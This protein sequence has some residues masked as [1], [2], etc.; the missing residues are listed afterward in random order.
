MPLFDMDPETA[1]NLVNFGGAMMANAGQPG[2]SFAGAAGAGVAGMQAGRM[3]QAELQSK[4][5]QNQMAGLGL[6]RSQAMQ[7][8]FLKQAQQMGQNNPNSS[9]GNSQGSAAD[10]LFQQAYTTALMGGDMKGAADVLKS[11]AEHN[12]ALAGQISTQQANAGIIKDANGNIVRAGNAVG[13]GG[14]GGNNN[15]APSAGQLRMATA[16]GTSNPP[17]TSAVK[18]DSGDNTPD[19]VMPNPI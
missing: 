12:P 2:A 6:Q 4:Q 1:N 8:F 11:W 3:Q 14:G 16:G 9:G 17:A 10:G 18:S 19:N 5:M 13:S 15:P 7:P